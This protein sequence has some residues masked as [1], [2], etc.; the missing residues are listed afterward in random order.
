MI[1]KYMELMLVLIMVALTLWGLVL[2]IVKFFSKP[3]LSDKMVEVDAVPLMQDSGVKL[4]KESHRKSPSKIPLGMVDRALMAHRFTKLCGRR[5][6]NYSE[7]IYALGNKKVAGIYV[8]EVNGEP[9]FLTIQGGGVLNSKDDLPVFY[10]V[11]E[12]AKGPVKILA[13]A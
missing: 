13:P 4:Y 3:R 12:K 1:F 8:H 5:L 7:L 10:A 6:S 2:A 9:M 11:C